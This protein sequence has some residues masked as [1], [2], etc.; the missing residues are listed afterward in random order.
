M[1]ATQKKARQFAKALNGG[2][3]E[4]QEMQPVLRQLLLDIEERD[5]SYYNLKLLDVPAYAQGIREQDAA[6]KG[7]LTLAAAEAIRFC[8]DH[9]G[10][11]DYQIRYMLEGLLQQLLRSTLELSPAAWQ[12][13][14]QLYGLEFKKP[15][16][17]GDA[18]RTMPV[19]LT[20]NQLEKH[21]KKH[22]PDEQ[23]TAYLS[24]VL[25]AT[26][27]QTSG[28]GS[29][30]AV[31]V[32]VK[33]QELLGAKDDAGLPT[34][35]FP[36]GDALG[37]ALN[38]FVDGLAPAD[39]RTRP[40]LQLLQTWQKASG[41]QPSAKY[42]KEVDAAVTAIGPDEVRRQGDAWLRLLAALPVEERQHTHTYNDDSTYTYSSW[43]F[44]QEPSLNVGKALAWTLGPLADTAVLLH[45]AALTEKCY[46]KIPGR[47]PL[48]VGLG[49]ACLLALSQGGLPGVAQLSRLRP[50]VRQANTQELIGRY[51]EKGAEK[52]GV[53]PAEIEDMAVPTAGLT[54]GRA[55]YDYGNYHVVLQLADGKADVSWHKG[56]KALKSAP[57][58]LKQ[59]H[60][61]ELKELKADQTQAQQ[62]YTTQR[63]RLDRSFVEGRRMPYRW[64]RQYYLEHG[65]VNQLAER[66]IWRFYH[67]DGTHTDALWLNGAWH[68]AQEKPV[69]TPADEAQVQLWHPVLAATDEV[70]A[71][72]GLLER[73]EL[74]QPL[75][76]AFREVY[77]L[78]PP[79]ERTRTYSNRMAAHVL[80]QHQFNSLAKLRGWRYSL[81]G[82][83]DKGYESDAARLSLPAPDLRAEFWVSEVNADG[84]WNDTGIWHY[85]STDQLRFTRLDGDDALPLT[86]IPPLV[87]SEVMRDVDLFVGVASVG[88][89]PL[90]RDGGGLV[91]YRNY[92][93]SYSFGELS[94][95]AK[96]RKLVLQR[97]VPR[98]KIG[99]VSEV[100]DKFLVVRG[101][102][103]TYKIHMGSGN[104]LMEPN[105]QYLCIVPDRSPKQTAATDVFLPFEGDAILSI[106]LSKALLLADDDKITD[107][108]ITRQIKS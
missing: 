11:V 12:R 100:Q 28:Y 2:S 24:Q 62:T 65:L 46:R 90:W 61:E 48:A 72:R 77:L 63:D 33:L 34:V 6:Y 51:I 3:A 16:D 56:D 60:A 25:A 53:T 98:L 58:A 43:D 7:R 85:V 108:T 78:T 14:L 87:F 55:D 97:L 40:W 94:E 36:D 54:N 4:A 9:Y 50:K 70:L 15:G 26:E 105:D 80:K 38:E 86:D 19:L 82:A 42:L 8:R 27:D 35:R 64:F 81:M 20:L 30:N 106:I 99:K 101:K 103:R 37:Q 69:P 83:Y 79:E 73:R 107:E 93:E 41:G 84:A 21:L 104:I 29:G 89:D 23:L 71:W 17:I 1:P 39:A 44:L 76:Q 67:A 96:N 32:R 22:G 10:E 45:L 13:L 92:W 5:M 47:G 52:L 31:K 59:S 88:N 102:L 74:R 91:Q 18:L 95:V 57:A 49:N 66:L 75:K 68:D